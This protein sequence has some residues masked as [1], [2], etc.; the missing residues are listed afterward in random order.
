MEKNSLRAINDAELTAVELDRRIHAFI[1]CRDPADSDFERLA[2]DVFAYQYENNAA[3]QSLCDQC[4]RSPANVVRWRDVPA[5]SASSF[6]DAR[7]ACFPPERAVV[8]F[9]SSGTTRA[10]AASSVHELENTELYDAS[11]LAHFRRCVVPDRDSIPMALLSPSFAQAPRSSL[12]YML[13][14]VRSTFASSG[15]FFIRDGELD[16]EG[17]AEF[18]RSSREPVLVFGT[19]LAFVHFL[20]H[21]AAKHW[22]FALPSKSRIVETGGFK[23]QSRAVERDR[24]HDGLCSASGIA[25][26]L[27]ISEYGMCELGSQWYDAS[28][29][30]ALAGEPVRD[31][32]KIGPHW[33]R[34]RVVDPITA[35]ELP[36]GETGLLQCFDLS[37]RGSAAAVL[38]GDL[39]IQREDGFIFVGRSRSAPPKGC[40]I[41]IDAML[42]PHA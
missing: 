34:T 18:L 6:A 9:V 24:L 40:S 39:A 8:R 5:V 38:T 25:P 33:A 10:G 12:A 22:R 32:L 11:L 7:I 29:R 37:N 13:E 30:D 23:G 21:C 31:Q 36:H 19:A 3:Y 28:L 2:V 17:I 16:F 1:N 26:E 41:T 27:C 4:G 35:V 15:G 20:D 14:R 42:R